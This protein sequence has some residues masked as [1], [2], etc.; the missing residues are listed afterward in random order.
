MLPASIQFS[1]IHPLRYPPPFLT[2]YQPPTYPKNLNLSV[3]ETQ[4]RSSELNRGSV[5]KAC[6]VFN[7][8]VE[9]GLTLE[10]FFGDGSSARLFRSSCCTSGLYGS[11][12]NAKV[13]EALRTR[14]D[15]VNQTVFSITNNFIL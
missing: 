11:S 5:L 15:N 12:W 8:A 4:L 2:S 6:A 14:K 1:W 7:F 9:T 3:P 13:L 10:V